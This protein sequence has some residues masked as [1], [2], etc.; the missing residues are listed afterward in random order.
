MLLKFCKKN[1]EDLE[2]EKNEAENY[3]HSSDYFRKRL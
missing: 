1:N 2:S 3:H